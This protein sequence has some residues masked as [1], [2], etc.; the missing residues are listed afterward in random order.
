MGKRLIEM[1]PSR[2]KRR[3]ERATGT[4]PCGSGGEGVKHQHGTEEREQHC[5]S[6]VERRQRVKERRRGGE[7]EQSNERD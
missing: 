1:A 4:K 7:M 6:H 3:E 5:Q 2:G